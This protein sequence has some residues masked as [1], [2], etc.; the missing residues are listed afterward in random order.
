MRLH[1]YA[2]A[3]LLS[4]MCAARAAAPS[5]APPIDS[6]DLLLSVSGERMQQSVIESDDFWAVVVLESPERCGE[7]CDE[8]RKIL[9]TV[10]EKSI[11]TQNFAV[12]NSMDTVLD[13]S[14]GDSL[15][16]HRLYN[17]TAV[18]IIAIYGAGPKTLRS[19][20]QLGADSAVSII[21]SGPKALYQNLKMFSPSLVQTV[22]AGTLEQFLSRP[23]TPAAL[24]RVLLVTDKAERPLLLKKLSVDFAARAVFGQ[25]D[26][27]DAKGRL[28]AA[29]G[30]NK[31]GA[32]LLVSPAGAAHGG[33]ADAAALK[34]L[35]PGSLSGW[36]RY[37]GGALNYAALYE[38]LDATL[39]RAP[40]TQLRSAA[41]FEAACGAAP[42]VT[43]CFVAVLPHEAEAAALAMPPLL[44]D[45]ERQTCN[46]ADVA[47]FR[48]RRRITG[49]EE[50]DDG[51]DDGDDD[52]DDDDERAILRRKA[53][54][55]ARAYR[56][57]QKVAARAFIRIDWGTLS[58]NELRAERMPISVAWIDAAEQGAW[59]EAFKAQTPGLVALNPRKRKFALMRGTF[60]P[61]NAYDFI[62]SI[63][64]P[65]PSPGSHGLPPAPGA[66]V[67]F[68]SIESLPP[69]VTQA[70]A[71]RAAPAGK[72]K[73]KKAKGKKKAKDEL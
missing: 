64:G 46:P 25:A 21:G 38:Y 22:R 59:V 28:A 43:L 29:L 14:T 40:L 68:E 7:N 17:I 70:P 71:K 16:V 66:G 53:L 23:S 63:A 50:S 44:S 18:P 1:A 31:S 60:S 62:I 4:L 11:G 48:E 39:P 42:D 56:A 69:L 5:G 20:L 13:V 8:I 54:A 6:D 52:D 3:L 26:A 34:A 35:A 37:S 65:P 41:D 27:G 30:T 61:R 51:D 73:A 24:P 58:S 12:V 57:L 72:T 67:A 15:E 19:S 10:A 36:A 32:T 55:G 49:F 9:R 45:D 47:C 33:A 2:G